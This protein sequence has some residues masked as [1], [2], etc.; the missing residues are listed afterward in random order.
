MCTLP[1]DAGRITLFN[2]R[3]IETRNRERQETPVTDDTHRRQ[4]LSIKFGIS[5]G[6]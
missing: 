4:L 6:R 3:L 5:I 2:D 1:T